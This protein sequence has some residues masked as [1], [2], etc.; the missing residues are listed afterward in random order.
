[1]SIRPLDIARSAASL[2]VLVAW[3]T[4]VHPVPARAQSLPEA[5][6]G[7]RVRIEAAQV[8]GKFVLTALDR[9]SLIVTQTPG[10]EDITVP[11]SS[12]YRLEIQDGKTSRLR[13]GLGGIFA[14]ALVG[15][16]AAAFCISKHYRCDG[17]TP[18]QRVGIGAAAGAIVGV[19]AWGG[20]D[21]WVPARLVAEPAARSAPNPN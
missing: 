18:A 7:D 6:V 12:V 10:A 14:G 21:R 20:R 1:M 3:A 5:Q 8:S 11:M 2:C 4:G 17:I 9:E 15:G 16:V 19:V 13:A